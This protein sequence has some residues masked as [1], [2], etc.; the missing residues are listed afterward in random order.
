MILIALPLFLNLHSLAVFAE[1]VVP[2][3]EAPPAAT[4]EPLFSTNASPLDEDNPVGATAVSG[5]R[6]LTDA[7]PWR[8]PSYAHQEKALGYGS[9]TFSIPK[10]MEKQVQFWVDIYTKYSTDQGVIHDSENIDLI[11]EVI[12]F[13]DIVNNGGLT[14]RAKE[15]L[16]QKRVRDA[17]KRYAA[18]LEYFRTVKSVDEISGEREKRIWT[19]FE[20]V[21]EPNKF[22]EAARKNRL[23]FQLGQ[24]DRMQAAIFFS[25]RYLEDMESIFR[26]ND[27]PIELTRLAFVESS[28]N[29]L[30]RSRVGAS[31]LWQIMPYTARPYRY[32][33][34]SVDNRNSPLEATRL[35]VRLLRDNY[36][37]LESWPLA[38]TGWNH[39]PTGV[40]KMTNTYKT[41]D[42]VDLV[43][44]VRSRKS[45]GFA[46]RNFYASFLAALDVEKNAKKYFS[47]VSWS[48]P[49]KAKTF[50]LPVA[51]KYKE[52]LAWFGGDDEKTQVFNPHLTKF[53][54]KNGRSIPARTTIL[55][56]EE[57]YSVILVALGQKDRVVA[58]A[59]SEEKDRTYKVEPGD[60][61]IGIAKEYGIKVQ[62]LL[63]QNG[64]ESASKLLPGQLLRIPN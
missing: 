24:K 57:K 41:R 59:V 32:I 13:R 14:V 40:R 25:G 54:R 63:S 42:L 51:I 45:F 20:S 3:E 15:K 21:D 27:L 23:R 47:Q 64:I 49:L 34:S 19:Y 2:A 11:Y 26:E 35:A 12:D 18:M 58:S 39:G 38:V 9:E 44:N 52:L 1:D 5:D 53:V 33:T 60:T 6:N 22:R 31:G 56:P 29:I 16:K 61:L 10:G 36:R 48:Q 46:S 4:D 8:E 55:V 50:K 62:D 28:F 43:E 37:M 17:E 30:A 7:R